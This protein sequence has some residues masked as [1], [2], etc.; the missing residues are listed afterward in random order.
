[1]RMGSQVVRGHL[2]INPSDSLSAMCTAP[3]RTREDENP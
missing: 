3:H 2:R 1:M